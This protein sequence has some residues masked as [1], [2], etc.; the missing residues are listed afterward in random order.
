MKIRSR[1]S[2]FQFRLG[3]CNALRHREDVGIGYRENV[4]AVVKVL[5]LHGALAAHHVVRIFGRQV[6]AEDA[7]Q[8]EELLLLRVE[9]PLVYGGHD[10]RALLQQRDGRSNRSLLVGVSNLEVGD[11]CKPLPSIDTETHQLEQRLIRTLVRKQH[12]GITD[13]SSRCIDLAKL[14]R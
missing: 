5:C 8:K 12:Q 10:L 2:Q 11:R 1:L 13:H 6:L 4:H 3:Q 9:K 14:A 7:C